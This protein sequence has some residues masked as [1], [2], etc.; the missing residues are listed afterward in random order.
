MESPM[1]RSGCM[2]VATLALVLSA[3]TDRAGQPG[4]EATPQATATV[5][6]DTAAA[7]DAPVAATDGQAGIDQEAQADGRNSEADVD[8]SIDDLLGDHTA[9]RD[10]FD[11]LKQALAAGDKAAVAALVTYPLDTRVDG[12]P[13]TISNAG[14]FVAAW[15]G[16]IT[17]G[18]VQV[19]SRQEYRDLFVNAKGVR[20]GDGQVWINGTCRDN[21]CKSVE[22]G[23]SAIQEGPQ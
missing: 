11:R 22:V 10:V 23:V 14:E 16:I 8:R 7:T 21:A 4:P 17:P 15:D 5:V 12:K 3:C 20:R 2:V 6:D 19:V 1:I 18:I 13:R 9:Y